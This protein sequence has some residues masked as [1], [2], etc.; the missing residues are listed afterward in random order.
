MRRTPLAR[1]TP[2]VSRARLESRSEL[3]RATQLRAKPPALGAPPKPK[4]PTKLAHLPK[5]IATPKEGN[6]VRDPG[7]LAF[8]RTLPC[9]FCG[10]T[11]GVQVSHFGEHGMGTKASDHEAV[12]LCWYHHLEEWHRHGTL[13]GR[14]HDEWVAL[15]K[16]RAAELLALYEAQGGRRSFA[17]PRLALD[18]RARF[19]AE[20]GDTEPGE[21]GPLDPALA[22]AVR[23]WLLRHVW[24]CIPGGDE[25]EPCLVWHHGELL[26]L[27]ESA[28]RV[29]DLDALVTKPP[30]GRV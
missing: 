26:V 17:P 14:T 16:V 11:I 15:W 8:L 19:L 6:P 30:K 2:L 27:A 24:P 21:S 3:K 4:R 20:F 25:W 7:F 28:G 22:R 9:E 23:A 13:P 5:R 1:K 12:P 10:T 29:V 18:W